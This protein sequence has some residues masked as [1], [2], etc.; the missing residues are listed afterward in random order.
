MIV[1]FNSKLYNKH[2]IKMQLED[3]SSLTINRNSIQNTNFKKI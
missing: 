3:S 1:I 2:H